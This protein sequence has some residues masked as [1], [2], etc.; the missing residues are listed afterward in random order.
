[1]PTALRGT[2]AYPYS[3]VKT[4]VDGR[5]VQ[6]LNTI[7]IAGSV[8]NILS[9]FFFLTLSDIF[10]TRWPFREPFSR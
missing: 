6:Q 1:M 4:R 10:R 3:A 2:R 5:S 7:P 8:I 9:L